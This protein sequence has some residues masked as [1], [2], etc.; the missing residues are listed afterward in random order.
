MS[1]RKRLMNQMNQMYLV[2]A[3]WAYFLR[4]AQPGAD[5]KAQK[6]ATTIFCTCLGLE[7]GSLMCIWFIGVVRVVVSIISNEPNVLGC[8]KGCS[9]RVIALSV[10]GP[11]LG[12][13][14]GL[15][16]GAPMNLIQAQCTSS[17]LMGHK[18]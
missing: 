9:M 18:S 12:L 8:R 17:S 4:F 14:C 13:V 16:W 2:D 3:D 5:I 11:F 7:S 15:F 10:F 1:S 6:P